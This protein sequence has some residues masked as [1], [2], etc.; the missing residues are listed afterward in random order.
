MKVLKSAK[1]RTA[2]DRSRLQKTVREIMDHVIK[3]GDKA[4]L[5]YNESFDACRRD[6]LRISREEIEEA[7]RQVH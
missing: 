4:L 7:Y 5:E 1:Q 3:N 2:E 6:T